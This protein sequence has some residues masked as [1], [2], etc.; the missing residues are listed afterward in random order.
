MLLPPVPSTNGELGHQ[1]NEDPFEDD[2]PIVE[3]DDLIDARREWNSLCA[4]LSLEND[5]IH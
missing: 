4:L 5:D 2:L 1:G 3:T